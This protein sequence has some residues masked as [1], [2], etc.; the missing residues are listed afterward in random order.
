MLY[1]FKTRFKI[2]GI[3][4]I[5]SQFK[6]DTGFLR[7]QPELSNRLSTRLVS[8]PVILEKSKQK[9]SVGN[10]TKRRGSCS[11]TSAIFAD[12]ALQCELKDFYLFFTFGLSHFVRLIH[13]ITV[14]VW[15]ALWPV[16]KFCVVIRQLL[17]FLISVNLNLWLDS[18]IETGW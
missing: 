15:D 3:L 10:K 5:V 11:M 12:C 7:F 8:I 9:T 1:Q 17:F 14:E 18:L 4:K 6:H 2:S 13:G 16:Y